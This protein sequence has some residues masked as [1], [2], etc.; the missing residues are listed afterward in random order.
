M[1]QPG[2]RNISNAD[3]AEIT[4]ADLGTGSF[5]APSDE[6]TPLIA[7]RDVPVLPGSGAYGDGC[8]VPQKC[9]CRNC[10]TEFWAEHSCMSRMCPACA[11]KWARREAMEAV[12]QALIKRKIFVYHQATDTFEGPRKFRL[13]HATVSMKAEPKDAF[14]IKK[15]I[16]SIA[17]RHGVIGF[18]IIIHHVREGR[19]KGEWVPDGYIHAHLIGIVLSSGFLT[20]PALIEKEERE[21]KARGASG[22]K[23]EYNWIFK[24]I[25]QRRRKHWFLRD[26]ALFPIIYYN[27]THCAIAHGRHSLSYA[28]CWW[29]G[30]NSEEEN[31]EIMN[32]RTDAKAEAGVRCPVCQGNDVEIL[33]PWQQSPPPSTWWRRGGN[34]QHRFGCDGLEPVTDR[35]PPGAV[36]VHPHR[37]TPVGGD[38]DVA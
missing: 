33:E 25:K 26:G 36:A 18:I 6:L 10:G 27:L 5:P 13:I 20:L 35:P 15:K 29:D 7:L 11:P 24:V 3:W 8:G 22:R 19:D 17:K 38:L 34:T 14:K 4:D 1:T 31:A 21:R 16:I 37:G 9:R 30:R 32:L 12:G 28:G 23:P 2:R